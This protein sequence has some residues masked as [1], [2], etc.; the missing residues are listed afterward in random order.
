MCFPLPLPVCCRESGKPKREVARRGRRVGR[1]S[2]LKIAVML[3]ERG[4]RAR[5]ST[6]GEALFDDEAGGRGRRGQPDFLRHLGALRCIVS[7]ACCVERPWAEI[8]GVTSE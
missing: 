2:L 6:T 1:V 4:R 3:H 8:Q 7:Q 5:C